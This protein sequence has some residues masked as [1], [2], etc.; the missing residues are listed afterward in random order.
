M[1]PL[2]A[3]ADH[4]FTLTNRCGNTITPVIADT[5]CGY[6][7]PTLP[8]NPSQIGSGE[9]QTVTIPSNWVGRIFAQN[10]SCGPKGEGCSVTEFNLDSGDAFTPQSYDISNIQGFTQSFQIGAAGCET[11]TCTSADCGCKNAYPVGDISSCRNDSPVRGCGAGDVAFSGK[12]LS[13]TGSQIDS[14]SLR[15]CLLSL[16]PACN[17]WLCIIGNIIRFSRSLHAS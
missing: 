15:S 13:P 16:I 6:S 4:K 5:K 7:P 3:L 10:G 2:L 17:L 1:S 11:V 14:E 9:S 12:A 8:L